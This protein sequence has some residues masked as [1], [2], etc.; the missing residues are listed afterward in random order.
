[1]PGIGTVNGVRREYV[2][3]DFSRVD[4]LVRGSGSNPKRAVAIAELD[5]ARTQLEAAFAAA[6]AA[7]DTAFA[8]EIS[9]LNNTISAVQQGLTKTPITVLARYTGVLADFNLTTFKA[10][11]SVAALTVFAGEQ[12]PVTLSEQGIFVD[13]GNPAEV[14]IYY[15]SGTTTLVKASAYV[16]AG[17]LRSGTMVFVDQG[18]FANS[19][20]LFTDNELSAIV[21][22][23]RVQDLQTQAGGFLSIAANT[24]N[25]SVNVEYFTVASGALTF[26]PAFLLRV[27][28]LEDEIA[29]LQT[30]VTA[31]QTDVFDLNDAIGNANA[32][33]TQLNT[34]V[35]TQATDIAAIQAVNAQQSTDIAF[36]QAVD[37]QQATDIAALQAMDVAQSASLAS[38]QTENATQ[39]A[40]ITAVQA[41]VAGKATIADVKTLFTEMHKLL[42]LT[43]GTY[44]SQAETTIF[45]AVPNWTNYSFHAVGI[46]ESGAPY[47]SVSVPTL[48][49]APNPGDS[50]PAIRVTFYGAQ[51][52]DNELSVAAILFDPAALA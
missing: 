29:A 26:S 51:V 8:A 42:P 50:K 30:D 18:S 4:L 33:L 19:F 43:N 47:E 52:P 23:G 37:T 38:L 1:M 2:G 28:D 24:L 44:D 48:E 35:A 20:W 49:K 45:Y 32:G 39:S 12:T 11:Q 36:L 40:A 10:D 21:P 6:N 9:T 25:A 16:D 46:F 27:T 31:L 22:F 15:V 41:A 7:Q 13:N 17:N 3:K 5:T 14:G 34:T